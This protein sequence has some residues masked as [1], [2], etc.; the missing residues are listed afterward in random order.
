MEIIKT[1]LDLKKYRNELGFKKIGFVPTMG[2]LHDGH[3]SL[4]KKSSVD[5]EVNIVSIFVNPTQFGANEDFDKYPR[6]IQ[7]DIEI[8]K[9]N[10]I[11]AIFIPSIEEMYGDDEVMLKTPLKLG[12][13]FEGSLRKN[14]FDGVLRVVLKL[15]NLVRP[16]NAYFGKKDAQQL[17]IIKKMV[18]DLFLDINIIGCPIIRDKNNLAL[19]SRNAYLDNENYFKALNLSKA[20]NSVKEAFLDGCIESKKL[21]NI[22]I[23]GLKKVD[24]NYCK[25]VNYNLQFIENIID[26]EA[27]LLVAISIG[28]VRLL[29]NLWFEELGDL[30]EES[31]FI[32]RSS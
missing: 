3:V 22:A 26:F 5:N 14:H 23:E 28:G 1:K 31:G 6:D 11:D 25:I 2:A 4:F 27:I 24:V 21:E 8:C 19:S 20:I 18:R 13:V 17:L 30:Y 32:I 7:R 16:N 10:N 9:A 15:F 29:D 12:N